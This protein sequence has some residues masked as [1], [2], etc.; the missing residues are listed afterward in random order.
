M[1]YFKDK[2]ERLLNF[3]EKELIFIMNTIKLDT[4]G[5]HVKMIAHRGLSGLER[6]NTCA[7]FVAAGNREKYFGIE[8]DIHRTLDGKFVIFHDDNTKRMAMD[9]MIIEETTFETLRSLHLVERDGT[10]S[11]GDLIMPTLE[12]YITICARYEKYAV[13]E[14]KNEFK[15]SDIYR[16]LGM[17]EKMGYLDHTIIISFCLKNLIRLRK[18][19]PNVNAQFLLKDWDDKYLTSL[20]QYDLGLDIKHTAITPE[21]CQKIHDAGKEVN[22]WTVDTVEDGRRV[23]ECGV[24]Y[25]TSNILE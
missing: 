12:E 8:T 6:E 3:E 16:I 7:A 15:A 18:R 2:H 9:S 19:Y 11:R 24:D 14:L 21:L 13:L 5:T 10:R 20:V 25:I 23:I 1:V 4:T 17:I 22:C